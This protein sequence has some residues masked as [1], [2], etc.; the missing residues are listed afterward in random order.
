MLS[1]RP[2][3]IT[4][5]HSRNCTVKLIIAIHDTMTDMVKLTSMRMQIHLICITTTA[6]SRSF[7]KLYQ[8]HMI[9]VVNNDH[10]LF[11]Q[12]QKRLLMI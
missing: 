1:V 7:I 2:N 8:T 12:L 4:E 3:H 11:N 9:I 6:I 10:S 5:D